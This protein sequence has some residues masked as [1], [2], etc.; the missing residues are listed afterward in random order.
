MYVLIL[1]YFRNP[2]S[3]LKKTVLNIHIKSNIIQS[4]YCSI[5][6]QL[7]KYIIYLL[8]FLLSYYSNVRKGKAWEGE[9]KQKM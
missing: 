5:I 9:F 4:I 8:N 1:L 3:I 6:Y 2:G 7:V